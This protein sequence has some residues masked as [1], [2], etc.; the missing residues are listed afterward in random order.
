MLDDTQE[1]FEEMNQT[2]TDEMD[3][4]KVETEDKWDEIT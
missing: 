2:I 4:A 1:K 3:D